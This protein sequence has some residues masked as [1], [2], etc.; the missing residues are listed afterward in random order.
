M[1]GAVL[2]ANTTSSPEHLGS[3]AAPSEAASDWSVPSSS[4]AGAAPRSH[5][6]YGKRDR[7]AFACQRCKARKQKVRKP[8]QF[9]TE[10]AD[11]P[12]T[13]LVRR[14]QASMCLVCPTFRT[15]R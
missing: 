5:K 11:L 1:F 4:L 7:V 13:L 14:Q 6:Q 15:M 12:P 9:P 2:I 8:A 3:S 10:D